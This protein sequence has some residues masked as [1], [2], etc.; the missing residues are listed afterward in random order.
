MDFE[1]QQLLIRLVDFDGSV[2]TQNWHK[3]VKASLLWLKW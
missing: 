1:S 2:V 3:T